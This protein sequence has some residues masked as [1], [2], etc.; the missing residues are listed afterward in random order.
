[1]HAFYLNAWT[2]DIYDRDKSV[3]FTPRLLTRY[4]FR[5][6][7]NASLDKSSAMNFS[8]RIIS[9]GAVR[10]SSPFVSTEVH[11][12]GEIVNRGTLT[13]QQRQRQPAQK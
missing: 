4:N 10:R 8:A 5:G 7:C 6:K 12:D 9:F 11:I 1:M 2:C 13:Q 3:A